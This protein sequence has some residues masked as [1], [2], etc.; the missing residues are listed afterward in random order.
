MG[1]KARGDAEPD[2]NR[3]NTNPWSVG[4]F[5]NPG[6][7]LQALV[8]QWGNRMRR[9]HS[10]SPALWRVLRGVEIVGHRRNGQGV[11]TARYQ[12]LQAASSPPARG[13]PGSQFDGPELSS[14]PQLRSRAR[15]GSQSNTSRGSTRD[16]DGRDQTTIGGAWNLEARLRPADLERV[17]K[18]AQRSFDE[19]PVDHIRSRSSGRSTD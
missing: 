4:R 1:G 7:S 9:V 8:C 10:R 6:D 15:R 12:L 14:R 18:P 17:T 16:F 3:P 11:H 13:E 19:H 5:R 2:P